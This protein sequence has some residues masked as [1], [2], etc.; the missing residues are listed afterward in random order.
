MSIENREH[1]VKKRLTLYYDRFCECEAPK[2]DLVLV[3]G[4]GMN[5]LVWDRVMPFLLKQ[6][7]VTL[8]DL[9]GMGRS[10]VPSGDYDLDYLAEHLLSVAP[11]KA[12]WAGWSLGGLVAARAATRAPD[13]VQGVVMIASNPKFIKSDAEHWAGIEGASLQLFQQLLEEDWQ[14]SLIRFLALQCKGSQRQKEDVRF[15]KERLFHHGLPAR[16][17]LRHGLQLLAQSDVRHELAVLGRPLM[18]LFG[19]H[20]EVVPVEVADG[21]RELNKHA[22]VHVIEGGAHIPFLSDPD[23]CARCIIAFAQRVLSAAAE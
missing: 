9:P 23:D 1:P 5:S 8:I 4:W 2:A 18:A 21:C 12:I 16:Q 6:L 14:G 11:P 10:P 17:A 22:E 7:R 13:R 20:D 3:H 15:L 19:E